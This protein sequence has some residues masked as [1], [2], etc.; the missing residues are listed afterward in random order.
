MRA[1]PSWQ[2]VLDGLETYLDH[3]EEAASGKGDWPQ[4]FVGAPG[5]SEMT[6]EQRARA[7]DILVRIRSMEDKVAGLRDGVAASL[8]AIGQVNL[9]STP[10]PVYLDQRI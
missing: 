2:E 10:E 1:S 5:M 6:A 3:C 7:E 9:S 8:A 4:P